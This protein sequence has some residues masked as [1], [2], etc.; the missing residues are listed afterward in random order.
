MLFKRRTFGLSLPL[1][2]IAMTFSHTFFSSRQVL[3]AVLVGVSLCSAALTSAQAQNAIPPAV[4]AY[5]GAAYGLQFRADCR[6]AE[7]CD[8]GRDAFKLFGG[9]RA[10]PSLA[11]EV[12]YYYL[13]KQR[14]TWAQ[15]SPS[16]PVIKTVVN[17]LEI[18]SQAQYEESEM[19]VL[20]LGVALETDMFDIFTQHLRA[21]LGVSQEKKQLEPMSGVG[22][23][24]ETQVRVFPYL[25]AGLSYQASRSLRFFSNAEVLIHPDK[26]FVVLTV[27]A[28]GEF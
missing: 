1:T 21:G 6:G 15:N 10:T 14:L 16:A 3:R 28:G 22:K 12:S 7:V 23:V 17:N 4:D 5:V 9:Y 8:R 25:G 13:G 2:K 20:G 27:G 11:T 19:Q 24:D 18:R 26:A